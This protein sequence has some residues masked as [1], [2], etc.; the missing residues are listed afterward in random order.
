MISL[1]NIKKYY[2][3]NDFESK[4]LDGLSLDLPDKGLVAIFG[5]SGCGKSTLLN[6]I[7]GLDKFDSGK[8]FFNGR[9]VKTFSQ[10]DWDS[11]RNQHVGFVFQNYYLM[12]HL[13]V[14][15]NIS[16]A[17]KMSHQDDDLNKRIDDALALVGLTKYKKRL[18]KTLSGGQQ[19]RVAIARAIATNPTII[20]AD[21][22]TGALD[23]KN[24]VSVMKLL[25]EISKDRLVVLVT[26][27][28]RLAHEYAD[29]IV[30]ISYGKIVSDTKPDDISYENREIVLKRTRLPILTSLKWAFRNL[31]KKKSRSIPLII[32]GGI[33]FLAVSIVLSMTDQVN[34]YTVNAQAASLTRYPVAVNCYLTKSAEGH[35]QSLQ[36]FPSEENIII[37][38][39]NYV[40]QEHLPYMQ[41]DFMSY[42]DNM[43]TDYY[44]GKYSNSRIYFKMITKLEDD[45]YRLLSSVN[46]FSKL[47]DN[48]DFIETQYKLLKGDYPKNMNEML[49]CIDTYNR[50]DVGY[51]EGMGFD[52]SGDKIAFTDVIGK[53]Y[54]Y[55]PNNVYYTTRETEGLQTRY[56][57]RG[58]SKYGDMYEDER[59]VSMKIVG[60]VREKSTESSIFATPLLYTDE[61]G[62]YV[63]NESRNSDIYKKQLEYKAA[64]V[65]GKII[66][67]FTGDYF[68]E[69]SSGSYKLTDS[70]QYEENIIRIAAD[71]YVSAVY[72]CTSTYEDRLKIAEYFN[73][74]YQAPNSDYVFKIR[75][76]LESVSSSLTTIIDTFSTI[77]LVFSLSA[78]FVSMILTMVLTY[79]TIIERFKEIG[80]LKSIGARKIDI[81]M[82]FMTE[83]L[84]IGILAGVVA[85]LT[86]LFV[87]P[88]VGGVVVSM[89]KLYDTAMLNAV[90]LNLGSLVGWVV[91]VIIGGSVISSTIASLVPT[92]IGS[93]KRPAEILKD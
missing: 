9:D 43:P 60:I 53:E 89:V 82:M 5:S 24:S 61:M 83:N 58:Y 66:D 33:G 73:G 72:Y 56:V 75:D 21:E 8:F 70:Y 92:I 51:L 90:P 44:T 6:V 39:M 27:D 17:L 10:R 42:M 68:T 81:L 52:V 65:D 38:K 87:S 49:L 19:Q 22:P 35:T 29:R 13:S 20:L 59:S 74:Y 37:E 31:W 46:Y 7:G 71:E 50:I 3:T 48:K 64:S 77:L 25:K 93:S 47:P 14:K 41:S 80:L 32:A 63:I 76:Y 67:V 16:I 15:E 12:P 78:V 55:I 45:S 18:P 85:V 36:Q 88:L 79:I 69:R 23:A 86:A 11:Y 57:S 1:K 34:N 30:E 2:K 40:D 91:P 26:H 28:E 4:A 84:V 54:R 62:K